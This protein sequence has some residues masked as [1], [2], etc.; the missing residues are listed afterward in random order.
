VHDH[1]F[2]QKLR[3]IAFIVPHSVGSIKENFYPQ[4]GK[5]NRSRCLQL[6]AFENS[7]S[8]MWAN[9]VWSVQS[10]I[11]ASVFDDIPETVQC[12]YVWSQLKCHQKPKLQNV[13]QHIQLLCTK[14]VSKMSHKELCEIAIL[15]NVLK[16]VYDMLQKEDLP[17]AVIAVLSTSPCVIDADRRLLLRPQQIVLRM[18]QEDE[19]EPYLVSIPLDLGSYN[20]LFS[21]LGAS[22]SLTINHYVTVLQTVY[23][24]SNADE[25]HPNE[26]KAVHKAM[27]GFFNSLKSVEKCASLTGNLYLLGR[28]KRMHEA[29]TLI[30]D[31]LRRRHNIS[32]LDQPF[33][34]TLKKCDINISVD[35]TR[36]LLQKLPA[37]AQLQSLS[38]VVTEVMDTNHE[39][40]E[41][42][43]A[44]RLNAKLQSEQFKEAIVRMSLHSLQKDVEEQDIE[45]A[46]NAAERLKMIQIVG[47]NQL[48]TYLTL[49]GERIAES[50]HQTLLYQLVEKS[51]EETK[52]KV[53]LCVQ[54]QKLWD[55]F[56]C[57]FS[58]IISDIMRDSFRLSSDFIS[59]VLRCPLNAEHNQLDLLDVK[60]CSRNATIQETYLLIPG[61]FVPIIHHHLLRRD[62]L[63]MKAGDYAALEKYDP[64]ENDEPGEPTFMLLL[65]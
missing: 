33:F 20:A 19:I 47:V 48:Q 10:T 30:F 45:L 8:S 12:D 3:S 25:L 49:K 62:I 9:A 15:T 56:F 59:S 23:K 35:E 22:P 5:R 51:S 38:A 37:A 27:R 36:Q 26:M 64:A 40:V 58:D 28:D 1:Q 29:S 4:F 50:E 53:Y 54:E 18:V 55:I 42:E 43:L 41:C 60:L 34:V 7:I 6:V 14:L 57:K 46:D 21:K 16:S 11:N 65:R 24:E 17:D 63:L 31:D 2:L 61:T 52:W 39:V 32:D 13:A 44:Q